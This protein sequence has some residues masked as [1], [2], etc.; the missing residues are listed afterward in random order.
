MYRQPARGVVTGLVSHHHV[1]LTEDECCCRTSSTAN[2]ATPRRSSTLD[3][4]DPST[5]ETYLQ[6]P[7][8]IGR[9][10][11][12][13][14]PCRG[15]R[16]RDVETDDSVR[17]EPGDPAVGRRVGGQRRRV[18]RRGGA[19]HRQADALHA[20]RRV[21]D[22][23]RS[24]SLHGDARPQPHWLGQRLVRTRLRLVRSPRARRRV[25]SGGALELPA[26]DGCVEV[27]SCPGR[28]QHR[29]AQ[30]VRH[31]TCHHRAA[32]QDRRRTPA[33]RRVEHRHR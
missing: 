31:H 3:I 17:A 26:D 25:R 4:V 16:L 8:S 29:G 1:D 30:A 2:T 27:R 12:R 9:R 14:L 11:R 10:H 18:H 20:R 22:A 33:A 5:G 13:R 23:R 15:T 6:A 7:I 21:P 28:R 24:P 32:R 19:Q